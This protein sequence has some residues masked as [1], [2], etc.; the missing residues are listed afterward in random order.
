MIK[1]ALKNIAKR[2]WG[3]VACILLINGFSQHRQAGSIS[4]T[5]MSLI[6]LAAICALLIIAVPLE[7]HKIRGENKI[8]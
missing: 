7:L 1:I 3:L 5:S 6:S 2:Y 4:W 8:N